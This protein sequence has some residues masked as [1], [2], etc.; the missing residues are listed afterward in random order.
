MKPLATIQSEWLECTRCPLHETRTK[1]VFGEGPRSA[2]LML[3]GEAP[4]KEEDQTGSPF[5]GESG[6]LLNKLLNM[7]GIPRESIFMTNV[8]GCR[9]PRNRNPQTAEIKACLPRVYET[10][11]SVDPVVIILMG[12]VAAKALAGVTNITANRGMVYTITVPGVERQV[13]YTA[14]V[15][16]H[17]AFLLRNPET[18]PD[19]WAAKVIEDLRLAG[20]L[21]QE[22]LSH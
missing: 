13:P 12:G 15:T 9:P 2:E 1:V 4:G 22:V 5:V 18:G 20:Q 17:P 11:Y 16:L 10:I 14:L 3:I 21:V 6:E 8:V 19:G 7:A